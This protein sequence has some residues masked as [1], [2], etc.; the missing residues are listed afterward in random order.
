[1]TDKDLTIMLVHWAWGDGSHWRH[2]TTP[3]NCIWGSIGGACLE[4]L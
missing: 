1:M 3:R 2:K 4:N